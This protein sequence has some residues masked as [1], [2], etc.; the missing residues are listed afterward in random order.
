MNVSHHRFGKVVLS[1]LA[2]AVAAGLSAPVAVAAEPGKLLIWIN[3]DKGYKGLAQLGKEFTKSTGVE[4]V[5][6][7]PEDAASKFQQAAA[8]GKGPD[9]W[10]WPHDRLGE[11]KTAGL[12]SPVTPSPKIRAE[13]DEM[14]WKAFTSGGKIWGYPMAIET[15]ALVYNKD[16]V[17]VAPKTFEEVMALDKKLAASGKKAILWD[18]TNTYFTWP[19][20]GANGGYP[21]K[22]R[23]DGTYDAS[24]TGVNNKGSVAGVEMLMKLINSGAMPK[25]AS[26]AD[27]EAGMNQGK[28]AMMITGPW[29]W[30][31]LKKSKINFGVAPIP[32]INGK[33][34]AP[35]VGVMGA[36]INQSSPNKELAIEF[37]EN[38][39]LAV[40]GLKMINND[41]P[42]GVPANKAFYNELKSN[43]NIQATMASAKLGTPMPS[44]L[45]MGKFW[46]SMASTLQSV[47]QGRQSVK[48]GLD[49]AA[50]RITA[51]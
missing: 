29:A 36:M 3:G 13:I 2:L 38:N 28:L 26:Y 48:A 10:I 11:W 39:M 31:N 9:I 18:F 43:P 42:L 24:N 32:A 4:V 37:I 19:L 49:A 15:V 45:E 46:S 27:M 7:R 14:G 22:Q 5:V 35:F 30:E 20:L 33:M 50:E 40:K 23:P 12:L 8:A 47:T 44:N 41:V 25:S 34:G 17:P 21:F 6:E 16:L 1:S 51:K